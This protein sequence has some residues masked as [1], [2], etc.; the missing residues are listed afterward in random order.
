VACDDARMKSAGGRGRVVWLALWLMGLAVGVVSL[1][2]AHG[3]PGYGFAGTSLWT[4]AAGLAAG[5]ALIAVGLIAWARRPASRFGLLTAAGGFGWFLL[6]WNN[7]GIGSEL[8]FAIGLALSAVGAPLIAHAALAYPSGRLSGW[9]DRAGLTAAYLGAG[10]V[11]GIL[12]TLFFDPAS[13]GCGQCPRNLLLVR[14]DPDLFSGL[15]RVGVQLGLGWSLGLIV[16]LAR[17]LAR[18]TPALVRLRIPVAAAAAAYLGL[19][20]WDFRHSLDRGTLGNDP[21]DRRLWLGQAA[22]LLALAA[23]VGW[24]WL[25]GRRTRAAVARLVVELA[26]SPAPGGLRDV[27]ARTLGD[28]SLQLA[29]PLADGRRVDAQGRT[30]SLQATV[31]PL[32]RGGQ[33]VAFLAHRSGLLDDPGLAEEVAAASRLALENER[34]HAELAAQ[35]Q[36]LRASRARIIATGDE[37][38]RRL[39]RDL[40]DGAQQRLVSLSLSLRLARS[41]LGPSPDPSRISRIDQAES[42]LRVALG[43]L[44]ELAHG[45]FPA[46]LADEGLAAAVEALAEDATVPIRIT[47]LPEGRLEPAVE[48]AAYFVLSEVVRRS[49]G[50]T[51]MVGATRRGDHLVVEIDGDSDDPEAL[52]DLEDRVGALDGRLKVLHQPGGR[53]RIHAEIP[54]ES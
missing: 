26:G 38:R 29:Y 18:S 16:L 51:M 40:H 17:Q 1:A 35:L 10:L 36:D 53:V 22:A 32:V 43:E 4:A 7:P 54:C 23:G 8:A 50:S 6:E 47:T 37:E 12:P 5:W 41:K 49:G 19:V 15:N 30:L 9:P 21:I 3:T 45:I 46:V 39:E 44:R 24:S 2:I 28:P 48:T 25:R 20:A 31:T 52:V 33:Q 11:L 14:D 34:L 42:E 27:L 13:Q